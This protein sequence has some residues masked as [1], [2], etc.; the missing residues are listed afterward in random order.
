M[1]LRI[2]LMVM[3]LLS[4]AMHVIYHKSEGA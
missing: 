3:I 2:F 1:A 4:E